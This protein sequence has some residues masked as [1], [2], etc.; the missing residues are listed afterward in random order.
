M[1][2]FEEQH[3]DHFVGITINPPGAKCIETLKDAK[4]ALWESKY[5]LPLDKK[6]LVDDIDICLS[7]IDSIIK[8]LRP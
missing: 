3:A 8:A 2:T 6:H 7:N 4:I 1:T 5:R